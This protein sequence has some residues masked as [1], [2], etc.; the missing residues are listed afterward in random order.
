MLDC[1]SLKGSYI[2]TKT[3]LK[4]VFILLKKTVFQLVTI[5]YCFEFLL[6]PGN[7]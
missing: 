1:H 7:R 5:K 4:A 6:F 2:S 3:Q